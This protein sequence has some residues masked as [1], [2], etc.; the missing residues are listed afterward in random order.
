MSGFISDFN[1]YKKLFTV[2]LRNTYH[3]DK[4]QRYES[5][6]RKILVFGKS[7]CKDDRLK[8]LGFRIIFQ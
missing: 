3:Q 7:L 8:F 2:A 1:V 6:V 4:C 5:Y